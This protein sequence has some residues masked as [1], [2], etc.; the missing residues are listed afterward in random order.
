MSPLQELKRA[1]ICILLELA[2]VYSLDLNVNRDSDAKDVKKAFR[3]VILRVHP[4]KA[5]GSEKATKRLNAAWAKW[6]EAES[7]PKNKGGAKPSPATS[8]ADGVVQ[9][10]QQRKKEFRVQARAVMLTYQGVKSSWWQTFVNFATGGTKAWKVKHW[11]ATFETNLDGSLHAHLM[12]QFLCQQDRSTQS[13]AFKGIRPNASVND[14]CGNGLWSRKPQQ[15][16][17]RGMFYVWANKIGTH[18]LPDGSLCVAANYEP[19]WT[20]AKNRYQV[21]GRWAEDLWKQR[22]LTHEAY[23]EYLFLTRDGVVT[24][25]RNLDAVVQH[26]KSKK[27]RARIAERILRIRSNAGLFKAFPTVPEVTAWLQ[28]FAA[29]AATRVQE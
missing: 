12:L 13:F 23:E 26:E 19:C 20:E 9:C 24:R 4:D 11:T 27:A 14:Y 1:L 10:A 8:T 28:L 18:T 29:D 21:L 25:K 7:L 3:R 2:R 6:S 17:D 16:V 15:S 22:K 5:G